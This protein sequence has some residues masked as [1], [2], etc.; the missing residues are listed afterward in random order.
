MKIFV[1]GAGAFGAW[2]ALSLCRI[3][4]QV[5]LVDHLGPANDKSSSA[6]ESR[7]IRSA[8]GADEIYSVMARRSLQLWMDFF[9]KENHSEYF[10][11]TG[12]LWM[13]Q[14]DERTVWRSK[15]TLERLDI[16]HDWLDAY[17]IAERYP[18]FTVHSDT[19]ALFEPEGGALLAERSIQAVVAAAVR[20]GVTYERAEIRAPVLTS[21]RLT[22]LEAAD[23][24]GFS[25]DLFVFACG[26]WL[27]KLFDV[28]T[29]V[30]RPTRQDVFF[31]AV[32]E[33]VDH[34]REGR[35]PI[36]VDQR[37]PS[38]AYG[39]PDLGTGL[40][41]G[42]H[43]LGTAFDPDAP[44]QETGP[45]E[46]AGATD[47]LAQHLASMRGAEIKATHVCHYENTQNGDFL[48]D[49]H[50]GTDNVW[51][52]GG[53]SGHGFKHAPAI[54]EYVCNAIGG[55]G[56]REARFSLAAK[57]NVMGGRVL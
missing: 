25:A 20:A 2:I 56:I 6:G 42:F 54:A 7:I 34:V 30:I 41:L 40:K 26:S 55:A 32:P 33:A 27:P 47:Y 53:G 21:N 50:P 45:R 22:S 13:A 10:R 28:L 57:Q 49:L 9:R 5:T 14:A 19:V 12:V 44:R 52:V 15:D 36:W 38:I 46:I 39:F 23:G 8:Y 16:K 24:R 51:L 17:A 3:G 11:Q 43:R 37:E 48:I 4:H 1:V 29:N 35:L 18:Q 31:F